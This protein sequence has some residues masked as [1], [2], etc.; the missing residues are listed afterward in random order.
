MVHEIE[1]DRHERMEIH[2]GNT[3]RKEKNGHVV[4]ISRLEEDV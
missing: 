4:E 2:I 1:L 3:V